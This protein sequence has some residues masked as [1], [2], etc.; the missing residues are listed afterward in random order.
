MGGYIIQ[1]VN[2]QSKDVGT[3]SKLTDTQIE[4]AEIA[5]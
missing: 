5:G 2:E 4:E 3:G 1:S